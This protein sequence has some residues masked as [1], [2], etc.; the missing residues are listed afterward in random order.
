MNPKELQK[1]SLGADPIESF[2]RWFAKAA[3]SG[4]KFPEAMTLATVSKSGAPHARVVLLKGIDE[5]GFS[6]YTNYRSP[7]SKDL[8]ATGKAALVFYWQN[9]DRQVRVTG[10][11]RLLSEAES[12]A[13]FATRPRGSQI[14]AWASAQS[15]VL[16]TRATLEKEVRRLQKRFAGK[17]VPRPPHWGG[18]RLEP[19]TLEFWIGQKSR[20]HDRFTYSRKPRAGWSVRRLSP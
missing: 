8:L 12:D 20:L 18:F 1:F 10:K 3:R 9:L 11:V 19:H 4:E 7:K 14:G 15:Q 6:F 2:K 17:P 13:Y 16:S 5:R